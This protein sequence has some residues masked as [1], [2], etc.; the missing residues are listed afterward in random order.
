MNLKASLLILA[1]LVLFLACVT[2]P[3]LVVTLERAG[4]PW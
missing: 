3:L 1:L 2:M 4:V